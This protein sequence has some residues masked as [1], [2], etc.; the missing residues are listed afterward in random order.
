MQRRNRSVGIEINNRK[1]H[2]PW[3]QPQR[4][5]FVFTHRCF[6]M[7]W[8]FGYI[9]VSDPAN[10]EVRLYRNTLNVDLTSLHL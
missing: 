1:K 8:I 9:A 6:W 7:D 4:F 2:P 10:F 3:H 5:L